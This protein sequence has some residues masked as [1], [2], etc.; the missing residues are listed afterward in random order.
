MQDAQALVL[1]LQGTATEYNE[2]G[3]DGKR[4]RQVDID[5]EVDVVVINAVGPLDVSYVGQIFAQVI[6]TMGVVGILQ[7]FKQTG[8]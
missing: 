8:P 7:V 3:K 6:H 1:V 4:L 2:A 5:I